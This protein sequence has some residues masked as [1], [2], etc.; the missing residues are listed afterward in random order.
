MI[1]DDVIK[2]PETTIG[3]WEWIYDG[4]DLVQMED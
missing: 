2:R 3:P 1:K 4:D